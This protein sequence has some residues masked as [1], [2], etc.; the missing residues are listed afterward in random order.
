MQTCFPVTQLATGEHILGSSGATVC[1][2]AYSRA[3]TALPM[4]P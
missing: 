2:G 1:R 4:G 3:C